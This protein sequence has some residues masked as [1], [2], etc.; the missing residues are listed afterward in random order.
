MFQF[1]D[2]IFTLI[3]TLVDMTVRTF[4]NVMDLFDRAG[5]GLAFAVMTIGFMP[6]FI[7]PVLISL[8]SVAVVKLILSFGAR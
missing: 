4:Q 2:N 1:F 7:I 6:Y 3:S 8:L 5:Q